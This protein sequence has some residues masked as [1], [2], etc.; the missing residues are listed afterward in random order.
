LQ[1]IIFNTVVAGSGKASEGEG[2][3]RKP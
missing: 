3:H 2:G 1:I